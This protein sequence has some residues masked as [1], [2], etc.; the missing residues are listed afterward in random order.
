MPKIQLLMATQAARKKNVA[1]DLPNNGERGSDES[2]SKSQN[3]LATTDDAETV[4]ER[5]NK[6]IEPDDDEGPIT[7]QLT[8]GGGGGI[9]GRHSQGSLVGNLQV[10]Q[11]VSLC[12]WT[13]N[14]EAVFENDKVLNEIAVQALPPPS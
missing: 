5:K 4:L 8:S 3:L 1:E 2:G 12:V 6:E 9:P 7:Q 10:L 13:Q 11:T 14:A